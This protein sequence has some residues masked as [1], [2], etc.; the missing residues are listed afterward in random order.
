MIVDANNGNKMLYNDERDVE[1]ARRDVR[2]NTY[3]IR[4]LTKHGRTNPGDKTLN[5]KF[6]LKIFS[7]HHIGHNH[8]LK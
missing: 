8:P 4:S 3:I 5:N 7:H 2:I 6:L 1:N